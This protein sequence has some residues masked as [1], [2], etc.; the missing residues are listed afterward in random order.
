MKATDRAYEALANILSDNGLELVDGFAGKQI[1]AG[2]YV[3]YQVWDRHDSYEGEGAEM[4][5]HGHIDVTASICRMGG[6]M[7]AEDFAKAAAEM[8]MAQTVLEAVAAA[9]LSYTADIN[10][11]E[12]A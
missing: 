10:G 1:K 3:S 7:S 8:Q 12:V 4:I 6:E 9:D 2:A 11:E 5:A